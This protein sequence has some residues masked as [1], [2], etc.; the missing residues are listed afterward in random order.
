MP[1]GMVRHWKDFPTAQFWARAAEP[2]TALIDLEQDQCMLDSRCLSRLLND[3]QRSGYR[4]VVVEDGIVDERS[5]Q[6]VHSARRSRL[7]WRFCGKVKYLSTLKKG[8]KSSL[9]PR[10]TLKVHTCM[11]NHYSTSYLSTRLCTDPSSLI[12]YMG[13]VVCTNIV[14]RL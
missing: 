8:Q 10:A 5:G 9:A 3:S 12:Q 14:D 2:T 4:N 1:V 13:E 6:E 11:A 7:A